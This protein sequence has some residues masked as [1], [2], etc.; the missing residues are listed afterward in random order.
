M[1]HIHNYGGLSS[2]YVSRQGTIPYSFTIILIPLPVHD[3]GMSEVKQNL[4]NF[5]S[6]MYRHSELLD[7]KMFIFKSVYI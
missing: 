4:S 1:I 2:Y 3:W 5:T 6:D 7:L